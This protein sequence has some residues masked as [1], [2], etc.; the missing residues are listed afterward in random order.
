MLIKSL[1][2]DIINGVAFMILDFVIFIFTF[3]SVWSA[4]IKQFNLEP[5]LSVFMET[6]EENSA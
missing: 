5:F 6:C 4:R 3:C 2:I 1:K